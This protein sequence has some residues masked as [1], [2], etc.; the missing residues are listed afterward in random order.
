MFQLTNP[1]IDPA[2]VK[3]IPVLC[4]FV[5]SGTKAFVAGWG[6]TRF[7]ED[8]S[9]TVMADNLR[10]LSVTVLANENCTAFCRGQLNEFLMCTRDLSRQRNK[11]HYVSKIIINCT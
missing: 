4:D 8:F 6:S 3:P 1:V 11:P 10:E 5:D 7:E 9:E 2:Y